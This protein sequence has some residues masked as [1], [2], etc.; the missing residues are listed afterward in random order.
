M[1]NYLRALSTSKSICG[2]FIFYCS[3]LYLHILNIYMS[4]V[5]DSLSTPLLEV[6]FNGEI[7]V[8]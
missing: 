8:L 2:K 4:N 3:S 7:S 1:Y 5:A 6:E